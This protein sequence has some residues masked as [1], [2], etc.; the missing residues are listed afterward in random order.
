MATVSRLAPNATYTVTVLAQ[1]RMLYCNGLI[2]NVRSESVTA[3]TLERGNEHYSHLV[4]LM[5]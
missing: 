3:T 4:V 2:S 1:Y 5:K